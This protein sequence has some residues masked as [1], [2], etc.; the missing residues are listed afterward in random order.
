MSVVKELVVSGCELYHTNRQDFTARAWM[1]L[2]IHDSHHVPR[3]DPNRPNNHPPAN[4]TRQV[5]DGPHLEDNESF[6]ENFDV[7]PIV[8]YLKIAHMSDPQIQLELKRFSIRSKRNYDIIRLYTLLHQNRADIETADGGA[9]DVPTAMQ[10]LATLTTQPIT[11]GDTIPSTECP[12]NDE[13]SKLPRSSQMLI[14]T[15][16]L[17]MPLLKHI[18]LFLPFPTLWPERLKQLK[19]LSI[20]QNPNEAVVFTLDLI[21]EI[22][23]EG[24]FLLACDAAQ[25]PAPIPGAIG[26]EVPNRSV[27]A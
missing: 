13:L 20:Q 19:E 22:M 1:E 15:M 25:I 16:M 9:F 23:E 21:D 14:H 5:H 11:L 18:V 7:V 10:S 26:S 27:A 3:P 2:E 17:P 6:E 4:T 8:N 12:K 24:G